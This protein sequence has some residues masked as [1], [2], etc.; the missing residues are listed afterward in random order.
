MADEK[1]VQNII[2]AEYK[3]IALRDQFASSAPVTLEQVLAVFGDPDANMQGNH[4]RVAVYALW[5]M[6]RY[7]YADAMMTERRRTMFEAAEEQAH[8]TSIPYSKSGQP[9]PGADGWI[10][11]DSDVCPVLGCISVDMKFRNGSVSLNRRADA[12]VW[13]RSKEPAGIV[14][15]RVVRP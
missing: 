3:R 2:D 14:A 6:M 11:H 8:P 10:K 12:L 1:K 9:G 7:E 13:V 5:A 4:T 15:Y